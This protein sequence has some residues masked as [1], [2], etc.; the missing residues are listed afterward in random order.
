MAKNNRPTIDNPLA[1]MGLDE[2]VRGITSPA[3]TTD[4]VKPDTDEKQKTVK[5]AGRPKRGSKTLFLRN[6]GCKSSIC[7]IY[8]LFYTQ[9]L[10]LSVFFDF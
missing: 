1:S 7:K 6:K 8:T 3:N 10:G 4:T 5:K 9:K 2:I